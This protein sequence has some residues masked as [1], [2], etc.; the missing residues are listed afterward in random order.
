MCIVHKFMFF[1]KPKK[2]SKTTLKDKKFNRPPSP[3]FKSTLLKK[4]Y[5]LFLILFTLCFS[6][7]YVRTFFEC[8]KKNKPE[9]AKTQ[10]P[11][12]SSLDD[13]NISEKTRTM[14]TYMKYLVPLPSYYNGY[15]LYLQG[16][17]TVSTRP[18]NGF[19]RVTQLLLLLFFHC[20]T[21]CVVSCYL[22]DMIFKTKKNT[23]TTINCIERITNNMRDE[24]KIV[25]QS[26]LF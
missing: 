11:P 9:Q 10:N 22:S 6:C 20:M 26:Q 25:S 19:Y 2:S 13:F 5:K 18:Y 15:T 1:L 3:F 17:I 7:M 12:A 24:Y 8:Y 14:M 16:H 21:L 23:I 4:K